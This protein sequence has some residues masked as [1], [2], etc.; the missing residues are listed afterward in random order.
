MYCTILIY[1]LT[2]CRAFSSCDLNAIYRPYT[3]H[4][5]IQYVRTSMAIYVTLI[6]K[7]IGKHLHTLLA[8]QW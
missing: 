2:A 7:L 8:Y 5:G 1:K 3:R 6:D 4:R